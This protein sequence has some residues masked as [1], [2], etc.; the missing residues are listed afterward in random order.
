MERKILL[1][2]GPATTSDSVKEAQVVPDICPREKEFG[3]LL[4]SISTDLTKIAGGDEEYTGVL[5]GGSGTA[6]MD[7]ALSS[8]V[9]GKVLIINN[10]AYGKRF[11]DI[12]KA[13]SIKFKE[14]VF[15]WNEEI[16]LKK[17]ENELS[18][19]KE[20][21]YIAVIHHETT[22]G[23]LNPIKEIGA[24]A[25]K[26]NC[27]FIVDAISSFA[28]IPFNVKEC[29]ID[30]M[31]STSNKCIQGMP[32]ICFIVSKKVELEKLK[33]Y[34]KK[35]FYLNLYVNY[36]YFR[37]NKQTPFTP[38]VQTIYALRKAIDEFFQEGAENRHRRY[39]ENNKVLVEG[40]E[41]LG[42]KKALKNIKESGLLTTFWEPVDENYSFEKMHDLA[43][44]NGFT[45][46]PGKIREKTFRLA[47]I[48]DINS[49]DIRNFLKVMDEVIKEM[50]LT[51][52]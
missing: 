7:A 20:I 30:F 1:T 10:G 45:I 6:G 27:V 40:M 46:Y 23:I 42:F 44:K 28:G 4:V 22:T 52:K 17:I 19:D 34:P 48:G 26:Y 9:N 25:K 24:L 35:S 50:N 11:V 31:I 16:D 2:P 15:N 3:N 38:P 39:M 5:F 49:N 29:N 43:Y 8:I 41:K 18:N 12:A 51:L 32:G 21:K 47:N 14:I 36:D 13:Y 33:N 37:Q